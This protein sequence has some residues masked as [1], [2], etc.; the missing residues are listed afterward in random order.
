[1]TNEELFQKLEDGDITARDLIILQNR[2]LVMK[3]VKDLSPSRNGVQSIEDY[4]S[5]GTIGLIKA[6][7]TFDP[8]KGY[9]FSSYASKCITNAILME[10]RRAV[11]KNVTTSL[12]KPVPM[13]EEHEHFV[14]TII[15]QFADT[16]KTVFDH[17]M[18][19]QV[20]NSIEKLP[21]RQREVMTYVI[22][23]N[24]RLTQEEI[25]RIIGTSQFSVS[26][27]IGRA[28]KNI[29]DMCGYEP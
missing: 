20:L 15:D 1:M 19:K 12:D 2:P 4:F 3:I 8:Q 9:K 10:V 24:G 5:I 13:P 23:S 22:S 21:N 28:R 18:L 6:V 11:N 16:E 27:L 25:G 29:R 17:I 14:S 7:D 26:R